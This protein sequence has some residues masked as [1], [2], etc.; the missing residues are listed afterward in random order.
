MPVKGSRSMNKVKLE[1]CCGT[2]CYMLGADKLFKIEPLFPAEWRDRVEVAAIPCLEE[3]VSEELC[4][5]P[6][7]KIDGVTLRRATVES[8]LAA[9]AERFR[10]EN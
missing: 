4:G 6:F 8:V 2:A 10:T 1:I 5:S 3:C 7:V 9:L